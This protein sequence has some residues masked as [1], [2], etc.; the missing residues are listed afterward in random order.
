[1]TIFRWGC[2]A[3][4][5]VAAAQA[6]AQ[7]TLSTQGLGYP[8]GQLSTQAASMGGSLGEMDSFSPLNPAALG[9]LTTPVVFFQAEPEYRALRVGGKLTRSSVTRFP[10]I[11]GALPLGEKWAVGLSASTLLDRTWSTT[12]RDTQFVGA[13]T[14]SGSLTERSD[15]SIA[16][17]RLA[18]AYAVVPWL[19]VGVGGHAYSGRDVMSDSRSFDDTAKFA[20]A[21]QRNTIGFGGNAISVGAQTLWPRVASVAV[22]YRHGGT[23]HVYDGDAVIGSGSVPDHL[24]VGVAYLGMRGLTIAAR[25]ARDKWTRL[26][27]ATS[28]TDIHE[29]WDLGVGADVTGPRFGPSPVAFRAGG[30]WRTLPFS[31]GSTAVKERTISG[32]FGLPFAL[33]RV[34]LNLG[35]LR[36]TRTS[37]TMSE[38]AWTISTGFAVRP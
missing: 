23:L 16:D 33:G 1:M 36:A 2:V 34:D 13:D 24:G 28:A 12:R 38:D 29:A 6:S 18:V 11:L 5:A 30:R 25:A 4:I 20:G 15:G 22:S 9:L 7:G 3:A 26:D 35:V 31:V 19:R 17:I 8:P 32:G 10:L 21:V 27:G 14:L 37:G